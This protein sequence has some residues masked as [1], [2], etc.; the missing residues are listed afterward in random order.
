MKTVQ[1]MNMA[2]LWEW[3]QGHPDYVLDE[4]WEALPLALS[5]DFVMV[6]PHTL[7]IDQDKNLNT[8]VQ[9]WLEFG[10]MTYRD[11]LLFGENEI[12]PESDPSPIHDV[13]LDCGGDTFEEAFRSLCLLVLDKDGD[14]ER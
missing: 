1:D 4:F 10:K 9:C 12:P 6:N 8:K 3:L 14:Y 2:E 13:D 11:Y 7:S 5:V